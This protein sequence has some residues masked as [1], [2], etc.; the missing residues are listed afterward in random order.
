MYDNELISVL[1][2]HP[3]GQLPPIITTKCGLSVN[4]KSHEGTLPIKNKTK[5]TPLRL[6]SMFG[7]RQTAVFAEQRWLY[8]LPSFFR[9][10]AVPLDS[11]FHILHLVA[12][13]TCNIR[14]SSFSFADGDVTV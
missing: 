1:I 12:H 3:L 11:F 5:Q 2:M 10:H 7:C 14:R 9:P 13:R 6:Q 4:S 8:N